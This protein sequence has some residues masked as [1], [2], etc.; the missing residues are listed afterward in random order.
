MSVGY[1]CYGTPCIIAQGPL[2][3]INIKSDNVEFPPNGTVYQ[4]ITGRDHANEIVKLKEI[5]SIKLNPIPLT[6]F[7]IEAFM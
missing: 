7:R 4:V 3:Q 2:K 5:N 1:T 6:S